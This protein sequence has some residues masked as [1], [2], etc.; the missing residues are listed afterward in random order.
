MIK[1]STIKRGMPVITKIQASRLLVISVCV[2]D[3]T[4]SF[5]WST[6]SCMM[7]TMVGLETTRSS[8]WFCFIPYIPH[9]KE[10]N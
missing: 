6:E 1:Q 10:R 2:R 4:I 7:H 5:L 9:P 3:S 8:C